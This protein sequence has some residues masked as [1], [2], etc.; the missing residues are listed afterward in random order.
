MCKIARTDVP[1]GS[2]PVLCGCIGV[3]QGINSGMSI[4]IK[5]HTTPV[6][7][8]A[9]TQALSLPYT[10]KVTKGFIISRDLRKE[11]WQKKWKTK[12]K[13]IHTCGTQWNVEKTK[14]KAR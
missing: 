2:T 10:L 11:T 4:G 7:G 3:G 12:T 9:N 13:K 1:M 8:F 5:N 6:W 14:A